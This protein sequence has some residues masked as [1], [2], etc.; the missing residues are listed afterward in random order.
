MK[1]PQGQ[2]D[3]SL[4]KKNYKT[5]TLSRTSCHLSREPKNTAPKPSY[6]SGTWI[7]NFHTLLSKANSLATFQSLKS[8]LTASSHVSLGRPLSLLTFSVR[9]K[10]PLRTGA[11]EDLRWRSPNHLKRYWT[12]FSSIGVTL[13]L[14]RIS[15]LQIRFRLV[16]PHIH[17]SIL[18]SATPIFC[19][20]CLL[21]A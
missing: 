1:P 3:E 19:I 21:V 5:K 17:R 6:D 20:C 15:S 11:S 14:S 16:W 9:L 12:S 13:T 7:A 10:I 2:R 8:L 18:I 4:V